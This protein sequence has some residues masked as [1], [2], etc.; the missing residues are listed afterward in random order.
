MGTGRMRETIER[1]GL[2]VKMRGTTERMG[3][4]ERTGRMR[5]TTGRRVPPV[6][7]KETT[8]KM[9]GTTERTGRMIETTERRGHPVKMRGTT[10]SIGIIL[11][12]NIKA[13][14]HFGSNLH[15]I[16]SA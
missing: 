16:M 13:I 3:K 4:T 2:P 11:S 9:K 1:R 14:A 5:E 10:G 8:G 15:T 12:K 7:T 6:K